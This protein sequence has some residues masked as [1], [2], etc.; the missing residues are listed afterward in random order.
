MKRLSCL[1]VLLR[2]KVKSP[3]FEMHR[4]WIVA[5]EILIAKLQYVTIQLQ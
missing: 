5:F 3:H 4:D 2:Q 1:F